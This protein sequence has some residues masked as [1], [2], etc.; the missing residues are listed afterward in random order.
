MEDDEIPHYVN[1]YFIQNVNDVN[2]GKSLIS[3]EHTTI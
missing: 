3:I 2:F 1:K